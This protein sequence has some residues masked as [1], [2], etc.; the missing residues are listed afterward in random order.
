MW[1]VKTVCVVNEWLT[2]QR[3]RIIVRLAMIK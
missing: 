1:I 2:V 3:L